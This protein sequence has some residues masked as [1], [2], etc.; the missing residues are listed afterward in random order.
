LSAPLSLNWK[1]DALKL[2]KGAGIAS[3]G[4]GLTYLAAHIGDLSFGSYT[5]MVV[6]GFSWAVQ[7]AMKFLTTT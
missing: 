7:W 5:P 1:D 3:A 2:A 6:A 4:A